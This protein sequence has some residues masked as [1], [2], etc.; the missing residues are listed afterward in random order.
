MRMVGLLLIVLTGLGMGLMAAG[1]LRRRAG[2]LEQLGRLMGRM[3]DQIR[4]TAAP[5]EELLESA[6]RSGEFRS[7]PVLSRACSGIRDGANI[8]DAW[9]QAVEDGGREAGLTQEDRELLLGFG[10]GLGT[11]DVEGQVANCGQ[12]RE[13]LDQRLLEAR[14]DSENK[15]RLYLTLGFSIGMAAALL[16]L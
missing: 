3:A 9:E 12:Y 7:L 4:Y 16:L 14:K 6:E 11:T 10:A 8:H 15:G 1:G 13:L 2:S 5:V